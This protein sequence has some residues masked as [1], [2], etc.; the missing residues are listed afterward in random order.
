MLGAVIQADML[1]PRFVPSCGPPSLT[2][3]VQAFVFLRTEPAEG[4][5][6]WK[7]GCQRFWGGL[8]A[9]S[10][11][12]VLAGNLSCGHICEE[13]WEIQSINLLVSAFSGHSFRYILEITSV[14]TVYLC[15]SEFWDC[16]MKLNIGFYSYLWIWCFCTHQ[17]ILI[18]L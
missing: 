13:L 2:Q 17:T 6:T 3:D 9:S 5:R 16:V 8:C 1:E 14:L 12:M 15:E 11:H 7:I 10:T 4:Q 18:S